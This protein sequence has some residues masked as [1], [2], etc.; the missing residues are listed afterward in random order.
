M[1]VGFA[2][3]FL[4]PNHIAATG[5]TP[6]AF[7]KDLEARCVNATP[8]QMTGTYDWAVLHFRRGGTRA[9]LDS[10]ASCKVLDIGYESK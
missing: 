3:A 9:A 4:T 8:A 2:R 10:L 5:Q 1:N 6:A 7:W